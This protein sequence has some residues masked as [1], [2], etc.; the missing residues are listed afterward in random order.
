[1]QP[2]APC[3]PLNGGEYDDEDDDDNS[4]N[5]VGYLVEIMLTLY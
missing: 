1:V 3:R 4:H 5:D 2:T